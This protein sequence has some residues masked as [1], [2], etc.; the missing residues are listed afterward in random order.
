M[1]RFTLTLVC[2][3]VLG[4]TTTAWA[5]QPPGPPGKG[6][7]G[8]PAHELVR[9]HADALGIDAETVERI[10]EIAEAARDEREE[11]AMGVEQAKADLGELLQAEQPDRQAVLDQVE[12][13]GDAETAMLRHQL[14][15]L[16]DM[17]GL[18][19]PEQ[20]KALEA[21]SFRPPSGPGGPPGAPPPM[22][23]PPPG[24]APLRR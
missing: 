13:L 6:G 4:V 22:G 5:Q 16:L 10:V 12:V 20:I 2:A 8:A 18:L 7:G 15:V 24:M 21:M 9:E 3:A 17:H 23:G 1:R 14:T 19:T 11:L